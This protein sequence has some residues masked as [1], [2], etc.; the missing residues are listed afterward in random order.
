MTEEMTIEQQNE[1]I[2]RF[3]GAKIINDTDYNSILYRFENM[4]PGDCYLHQMKYHSSWDWLMPVVEK[5]EALAFQVQIGNEWFCTIS[6]FEEG[7]TPFDGI[8]ISTEV[9]PIYG[10]VK[11]K[12]T[13]VFLAVFQFIKW[14]NE[15]SKQPA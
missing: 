7:E 9:D 8:Y 11:S 3:M 12:I 1:M 14:Y 6:R 5:I 10:K 2:A 13:G 4:K 15:Q